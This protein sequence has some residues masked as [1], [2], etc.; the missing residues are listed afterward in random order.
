MIIET[1]MLSDAQCRDVLN[2]LIDYVD[3][4]IVHKK[5]LTENLRLAD[6]LRLRAY[7][8]YATLTVLRDVL[9][10]K[11]NDIV[12]GTEEDKDNFYE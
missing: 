6:K 10:D 3:E 8:Q 12:Y 1:G 7:A 2:G 11:V 4:R 9:H 5:S